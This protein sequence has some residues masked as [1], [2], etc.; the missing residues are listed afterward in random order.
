MQILFSVFIFFLLFFQLSEQSTILH[1]GL[2]L[3]LIKS[4]FSVQTTKFSGVPLKKLL[5]NNA[6]VL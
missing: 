3:I 5:F 1:S 6:L 4:T 2:I